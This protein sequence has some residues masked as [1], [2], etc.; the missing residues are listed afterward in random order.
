MASTT[1]TVTDSQHSTELTEFDLRE[2]TPTQMAATEDSKD[3]DAQFGGGNGGYSMGVIVGI[4]VGCLCIVGVVSTVMMFDDDIFWDAFTSLHWH[5]WV[6]PDLRLIECLVLQFLTLLSLVMSICSLLTI[7]TYVR[8]YHQTI[9]HWSIRCSIG[10]LLLSTLLSL[11][12]FILLI[13]QQNGRHFDRNDWE[14]KAVALLMCSFSILAPFVAIVCALSYFR[15][16]ALMKDPKLDTIADL[17]WYETK[18]L[19][20]DANADLSHLVAVKH[21]KKDKK[22]EIVMSAHKSRF[23]LHALTL[24]GQ[25]VLVLTAQYGHYNEE[26]E[27]LL[28]WGYRFSRVL[29]EEDYYFAKYQ[30]EH[31]DVGEFAQETY[32]SLEWLEYVSRNK[33]YN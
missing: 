28:K 18:P 20:D 29:D 25:A 4:A 22:V 8:K 15:W 1:D 33:Q 16:K 5:L 3:G 2:T 26:H 13:Y 12:G 14:C 10:T 27:K 7:I 19:D 6:Q 17:R 30:L 24:L 9:C 31:G 21:Q 32:E 23:R 11:A